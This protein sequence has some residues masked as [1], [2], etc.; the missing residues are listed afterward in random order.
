MSDFGTA[1]AGAIG[2]MQRATRGRSEGS[3]R[4]G[5]DP[6]RPR[7]DGPGAVPSPLQVNPPRFWNG[8]SNVLTFQLDRSGMPAVQF[9]LCCNAAVRSTAAPAGV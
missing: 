4:H 2:A 1:R 7:R 9:G 5:L 3:N 6:L 8:N